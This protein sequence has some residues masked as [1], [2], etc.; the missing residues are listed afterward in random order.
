MVLEEDEGKE[1]RGGGGGEDQ[2]REKMHC[3]FLKS[4]ET[5]SPLVQNESPRISSA[6]LRE[7]LLFRKTQFRGQE[8]L[9]WEVHSVANY[10]LIIFFPR[11]LGRGKKK[12]IPG[13][14]VF[15]FLTINYFLSRSTTSLFFTTFSLS[16]RTKSKGRRK[17]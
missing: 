16:K 1:G 4:G 15:V 6:Y 13:L 11:S 8:N 7:P 5:F 14:V 3:F 9:L 10:L 2:K 12:S 17:L